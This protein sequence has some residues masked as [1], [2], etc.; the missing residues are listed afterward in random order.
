MSDLRI[1]ALAFDQGPSGA[2]YAFAVDGRR[3]GEFA[4]IAR[5][6]R[7]DTGD[8]LGYQR[9]EIRRHVAAIRDYLESDAPRLP[10]ALVVAFD[11]SVRF[12]PSGVL[13]GN[14]G[15][16]AGGTPGTLVVPADPSTPD[17]LKP[18]WV[19]DGQQRMMAIQDADRLT[20]PFPVCVVAFVAATEAEQREQ[21]ILVNATKP[22]PKSLVY[23]LLPVT[24][25]PLPP[26]LAARRFP[27][28]LLDGLNRDPASPF[29]R[30]IKTPTNPD[31]DIK[32]N[33]VLRM[34]EHSLSDGAL[35]RYRGIGL[36]PDDAAGMLRV[37]HEYWAAVASVFPEAWAAPPTHSRLTHGAGLVSMGYLMDAIAHRLGD[38][39]RWTRRHFAAELGRVA[40][41]CRWTSGMWEFGPDQRRRWNEIQNVGTDIHLLTYH[42]LR[43]YGATSSPGLSQGQTDTPPLGAGRGR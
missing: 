13:T 26:A 10:N 22:L 2:L 7:D 41:Q 43:R 29:F 5:V 3:L 4:T 30:R 37:L 20:G 38:R 33:S 18:G 16:G 35:Y 21:F 36:C 25:G 1:P 42:L 17:H 31:G 19:V 32:D 15:P 8:L 6:R 14:L 9:P 34:V 11:E 24:D 28:T 23:E 12:E 27:A 39:R 40:P